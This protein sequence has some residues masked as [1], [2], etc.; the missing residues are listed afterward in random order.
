MRAYGRMVRRQFLLY[1]I[2]HSTMASLLPRLLNQLRHQ[3]RPARLVTCADAGSVVS[4]EVFVEGNRVS[5][6]GIFL[7]LGGASEDRASPGLVA[8]KD[9]GQS[10]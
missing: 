3:S 2:S 8:E 7:E 9:V 10:S 6:E 1:A 5:P 4:M